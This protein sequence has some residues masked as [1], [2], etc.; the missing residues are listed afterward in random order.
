M[1]VRIS[2]INNE[3][4]EVAKKDYPHLSSGWFSDV[5]TSQDI[6]EIDI[7]IGIDYWWDIQEDEE[8]SQ[9][10]QWQSNKAWLGV[11]LPSKRKDCTGFNAV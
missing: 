8:G 10:N 9:G 3:N 11:A 1:V 6:L 2:D 5:C 4:A 7:L